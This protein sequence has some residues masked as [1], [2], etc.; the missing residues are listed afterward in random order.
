MNH[1]QVNR[2]QDAIIKALESEND[3]SPITN[4]DVV[5]TLALMLASSSVSAGC[6]FTVNLD[7][8]TVE[9]INHKE[10]IENE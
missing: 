10:E 1:E 6:S 3:K 8:V 5:S 7:S 9:V 4:E 2:L